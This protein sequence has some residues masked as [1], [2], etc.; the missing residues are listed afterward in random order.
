[1][2]LKWRSLLACLLTAAMLLS[3]ALPALAENGPFDEHYEDWYPAYLSLVVL[4]EN[5]D[6]VTE[7]SEYGFPVDM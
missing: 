3:A 1:M 6:P 2:K 5:E 4:D 7:M